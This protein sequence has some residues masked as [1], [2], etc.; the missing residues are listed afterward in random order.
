MSKQY[1]CSGFKNNFSLF[2][3]NIAYNPINQAPSKLIDYYLTKR[4]ILS[5]LS[6]HIDESLMGQF[7]NGDYSNQFMLE[8]P[9]QFRIENVAKK[10][11][12]LLDQ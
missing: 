11:L 10:F 6:N 5:V 4:P 3:I 8:N 12:D 2:L 1:A 7:L 9:E